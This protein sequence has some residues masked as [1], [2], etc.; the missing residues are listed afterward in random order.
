MRDGLNK[1]CFYG[2]CSG[3]AYLIKNAGVCLGRMMRFVI[4]G[5]KKA[6]AWLMALCP[7][8]LGPTNLFPDFLE[9]GFETEVYIIT[10]SIP[11]WLVCVPTHL[12]AAPPPDLSYPCHLVCGKEVTDT[13]VSCYLASCF[14]K[15]HVVMSYCVLTS[16][17]SCSTAQLAF[18]RTPWYEVI[19]SVL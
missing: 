9:N 14:L 2:S 19:Y 12:A 17:V 5:C 7:H 3:E 6:F 16:S 4:P 11:S 13:I 1:N 18:F 10:V 15:L 8:K